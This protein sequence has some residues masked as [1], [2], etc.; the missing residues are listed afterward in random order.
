VKKYLLRAALTGDA[1]APDDARPDGG[2][3]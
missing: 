1:P 2:P 3:A